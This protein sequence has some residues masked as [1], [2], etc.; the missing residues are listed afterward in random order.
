MDNPAPRPGWRLTLRRRSPPSAPT[1]PFASRSPFPASTAVFSSLSRQAALLQVNSRSRVGGAGASRGI[2]VRGKD[3]TYARTAVA[4]RIKAARVEIRIRDAVEKSSR[5]A[6]LTLLVARKGAVA[7]TRIIIALNAEGITGA[8][9]LGRRRAK[10]D[11]SA[12]RQHGQNCITH[13]SLRSATAV[14][15]S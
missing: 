14:R 7:E 9:G 13:E 11:Q 10:H 5:S 2:S 15:R 8:N 4:A 1:L 12:R 6:G 3:G